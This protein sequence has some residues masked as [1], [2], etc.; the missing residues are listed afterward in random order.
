MDE[1]ISTYCGT[2]FYMAPEIIAK[3][4]YSLNVD[5]WA[6]GVVI[7]VMLFGILPFKS[8]NLEL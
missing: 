6:L 2:S 7:F 4:N 5:I 8:I 1:K 3:K